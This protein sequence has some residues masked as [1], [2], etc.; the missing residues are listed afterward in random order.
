[1]KTADIDIAIIGGGAAGLMAA[2][3]A[4]KH[5]P[6]ANILILDGAKKLGA[7]IL[8][9]GGG[10]CNVTHTKVNAHDYAGSSRNSIK[11]ILGRFTEQQTVDFFE[12]LGVPLKT[13]ATGKLFPISDS[14]ND[15]LQALLNA[16][17]AH[18]VDIKTRHRVCAIAVHD[19]VFHIQTENDVHF[20]AKRVIIATGGKSLPKT[21]S[22]GFGYHLC[23]QLGHT[24]SEYIFPALVPLCLP[25]N[26]ALCQLTGI[27]FKA[28]LSLQR[29]SG[30]VLVAFTNDVLCTHFGLSGPAA[31]DISRYYLDACQRGE[32]VQLM[33]N[34]LPH[35]AREQ[36]EMQLL[37]AQE[38]RFLDTV[39]QQHLPNRVV[40]TLLSES[41]INKHTRCQELGRKKRQKLLT[42]IYQRP[43]AIDGNRGFTYAEVTAGGIALTETMLATLESRKQQGLYLCGEILDVDGRIGGFNF[44]WA[45]ASGY[46][47]GIAAAQSLT[48]YS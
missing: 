34:M 6:N 7:K 48:H 5:A 33:L 31:L 23:Q 25:S 39:L 12:Q 44:Q 26:D 28:T 27:S 18:Q 40:T 3:W 15:V 37:N 11:K 21:G 8:V 20:N 43:L 42:L 36:L 46:T 2:I 19:D 38:K 13:E 14:A 41:E 45:W 9:A 35:F 17:R 16:C 22:D 1:M 24:L 29:S 30:K 4:A 47:A 10:R 32:T